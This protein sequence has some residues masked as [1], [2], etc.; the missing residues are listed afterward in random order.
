MSC[1]QSTYQKKFKSITWHAITISHD[2]IFINTV[3]V[4][5]RLNWELC[6]TAEQL[7]CNNAAIVFNGN[8]KR[9]QWNMCNSNIFYS[10]DPFVHCSPSI[11][12]ILACGNPTCNCPHLIWTFSRIFPGVSSSKFS[13]WMSSQ[14]M[15]ATVYYKCHPL[16]F[17]W[18]MTDST[19]GQI[20]WVRCEL[21]VL[22]LFIYI[23]TIIPMS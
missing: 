13:H 22:F 21:P 23:P 17:S 6:R 8:I 18:E 1:R 11:I 2:L 10:F 12:I 7:E 19:K 5:L 20:I 15:H 9:D 16:Y 4:I 3:V 14:F